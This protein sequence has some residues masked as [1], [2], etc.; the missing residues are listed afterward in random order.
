MTNEEFIESIKLDNEEW[1]D[2]VGY[3]GLYMVSSFGRIIGLPR[4]YH[5]GG[6]GKSTRSKDYRILE[7]IIHEREKLSYYRVSLSKN[8]KRKLLYAHRLVADAF[9]PNPYN[10]PF[11]DH[12]DRN[13]HNNN[14]SNLRWCTQKMN[15]NNENTRVVHL[16]ALRERAWS[17]KPLV[18]MSKNSLP[19]PR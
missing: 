13:G 18:N 9:I 5:L 19:N 2:V 11:I 17:K 4:T 10:Y 6:S 12:I 7:L 1:R 16:K 3:E 14:V 8:N 15:M